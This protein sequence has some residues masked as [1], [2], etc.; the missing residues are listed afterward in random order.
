MDKPTGRQIA[1]ARILAGFTQSEL[2]ERSKVSVPTIKR[3]EGSDGPAV[4]MVNNVDA[5]CRALE[6]AGIEFSSPRMAAA[7]G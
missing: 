3:L 1:A 5:V 7:P 2:A 4:G 6:S